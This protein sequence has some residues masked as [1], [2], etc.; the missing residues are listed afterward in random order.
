MNKR[1]NLNALVVATLGSSPVALKAMTIYDKI[2][3]SNPKMM[4]REKVGG[5]LSFVKVLNQ[6]GDVRQVNDSGIRRYAIR[7]VLNNG[8]QQV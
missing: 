1:K 7:K 4:S 3:M 5:F 2:R 6:F 8:T